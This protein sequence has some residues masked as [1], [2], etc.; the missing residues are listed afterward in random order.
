MVKKVAQNW[1]WKWPSK[2]IFLS[3]LVKK[4]CTKH[5]F[6]LGNKNL[7][8]IGKLKIGKLKSDLFKFGQKSCTKLNIF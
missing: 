6:K 8:K 5:F 2:I 1:N 7:L 3:N 4:S